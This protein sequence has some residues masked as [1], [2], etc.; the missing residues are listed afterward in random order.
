MPEDEQIS[1]LATAY[2]RDF[3][4]PL[5]SLRRWAEV[6]TFHLDILPSK[7][8]K[9]YPYAAIAVEYVHTHINNI[10]L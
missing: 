5:D 2:N 1:M 4:A 6:P 10:R 9:Y 8:T 7:A 3:H